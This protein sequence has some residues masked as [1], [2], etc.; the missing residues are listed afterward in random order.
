MS[1][2]TGVGLTPRL[3]FMTVSKGDPPMSS[4]TVDL[5]KCRPLLVPS[6]QRHIW[7]VAQRYVI[8]EF[9]I[10]EGFE[11]DLDSVPHIPGL[12]ALI[13]G[14]SRTGALLHDYLYRTHEVSREV[15]DAIFYE[16]IIEEGTPEWIAWSMYHGVRWFGGRFYR[17][18]GRH[19]PTHIERDEN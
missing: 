9:I 19:C 1:S 10:P 8:R 6:D 18:G 4:L 11:T 13:K 15:A 3:Y 2:G 16:L 12:F 17:R 14:R 5:T 7:V